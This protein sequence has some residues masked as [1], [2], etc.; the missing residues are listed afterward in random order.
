MSE[1]PG[2]EKP[3]NDHVPNFGLQG[4]EPHW[5][6]DPRAIMSAHG[7]RLQALAGRTLTRAW[8][9]WDLDDDKWFA[10]L[11]VVLDFEGEQVEINHYKFND[12]SLTWNTIQP[13]VHTTWPDGG[14][15]ACV[16][17]LAWRHDARPELAVLQGQTLEAVKLLHWDGDKYDAA[18]GSIGVS[19]AFPDG[20]VTIQN[21]LD[22]NGLEFGEPDP[23]Y[24][25]P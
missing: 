8:L 3:H 21:A 14:E 18:N 2:A 11:P 15:D 24:R 17:H 5:L 4:Y 20:R 6:T 9:V 10:D 25:R 22:E 12:L 23:G 16:F 13:A 19:F 7:E 1:E